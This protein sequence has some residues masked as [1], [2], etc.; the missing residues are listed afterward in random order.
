ML[1]SIHRVPGAA[2]LFAALGLAALTATGVAAQEFTLSWNQGPGTALIGDD[3][4]EIELPEAYV[5]L[6]GDGTRQLMELFENPV[7]GAELAT[8]APASEEALWYVVFEWDDI[9]FVNDDERDE[10]D[11]DAM[12]K[13]IRKGNEEAN[14]ERKRR[15]WSTLEI[16]GWQ[17]PPHYD[18][19][20]NNLTWAVIG[21]SDGEQVVNRNIRILGRRGVMRLALVASPDELAAASAELDRLLES[22]RFRPGNRYAEFV[23]GKDRV[24]EIGLTALVVGGAGALAVKSGLLARM[25]KVLVA[26][27]VALAAAIKKFFRRG[28]ATQNP[29]MERSRLG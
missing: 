13:S 9:G 19:N 15:G 20:T 7:S 27:V 18:T 3:L 11:P 1:K 25:W 10:L 22:Y 6:D 29:Q 17:E 12:L 24:A 16:V 26:G 28:S 4:A 21:S 23:P 14:K 8:I 5:W 2:S